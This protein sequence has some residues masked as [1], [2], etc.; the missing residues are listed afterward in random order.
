[1]PLVDKLGTASACRK[2]QYHSAGRCIFSPK[3]DQNLVV[4][5]DVQ[6]DV[7]QQ[8]KMLFQLVV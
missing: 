2:R 3:I 6:L 8:V 4:D 5:A 1:M 7:E